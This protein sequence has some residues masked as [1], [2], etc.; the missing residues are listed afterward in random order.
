MHK[1]L[2]LVFATLAL[3]AAAFAQDTNIWQDG[4]YQV[5][6]AANL[7]IGDS[8]INM[9]NDGVNGGFYTGKA[10]GSICANVYV[11]DAAEEEISCC[12]CLITPNGLNSLSAKS[13]LIS[14]T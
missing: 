2:T 10:A 4:W 12:Y 14:N 7:N 3:S 5:G 1:H 8:V 9:S 11:F 13:D 6:Y